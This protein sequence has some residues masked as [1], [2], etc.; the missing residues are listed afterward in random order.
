M[1]VN[2]QTQEER[3]PRP[4]WFNELWS[5]YQAGMCNVFILH[6]HTHDYVDDPENNLTVRQYLETLLVTR[7]ALA[8]FSPDEGV[9]FPGDELTS[10]ESAKWLDKVLG[11]DN[12]PAE[13]PGTFN[14]AALLSA[15]AQTSGS[16]FGGGSTSEP[17]PSDAPRALAMLVDY[18]K[19]ADDRAEGVPITEA[20]SGRFIA[21]RAAVL[22][23]RLD[24]IMPP[25]EKDRLG[26]GDRALLSLL[27]RAGTMSVINDRRNL[28][29]MLA[30]S[31]EE[32]HPDLRLAASGIR[33]IEVPP[34]DYDQRLAFCVRATA[35]RR[36]E[37]GN[38]TRPAV[39]LEDLQVTDLATQTAGLNRRHIEDLVLRAEVTKGPITREMVKARKREQISA[40]YAEVLEI[41]EP[42]VTF[43]MVGGHDAVKQY[44][45][46]WVIEPMRDSDPEGLDDIPMGILF[47]GPSGTGKTYLARALAKESGYNCVS[48]APDNIRGSYVG[49]SEKKLRK[50]IQGVEAMAPV[51]LFIDEIDQ[52]L[53]RTSGG[54]GGGDSVEGNIFGKM[55]EFLSDTRHRGSILL[56]A[57]TNEPGNIDPAL[58]RPGRIDNKIPLLPPDTAEERADALEALTRRHGLV[59]VD[60]DALLDVGR[61]TDSWTQAELEALV[62]K[63]RAYVRRKKLTPA[64]AFT[65]VLGRMRPSTAGIRRHIELAVRCCDDAS[66][67]PERWRSMVGT[68]PAPTPRPTPV[69]PNGR[70]GRVAAGADGFDLDDD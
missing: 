59:G 41:L 14:A 37:D 65:T 51:I 63:S 20:R 40:E 64:E 70:T 1:A 52:K 18:L 33:T 68:A 26:G 4:A 60:R 3:A 25:S 15:Q 55:L 43:D 42:D 45:R 17:L 54:G 38:V 23:E 58:Q 12:Q 9:L 5:D 2:P 16:G 66:L 57:A 22:V 56:V 19:Q 36:D 29:I 50:A 10:Q 69:V 30:P 53:R 48:M 31:L 49:E 11:R 35:E 47:A 27:H 28:M 32:I 62:V 13:A 44:L 6:G 7:Y 39:P 21:K 34:P 46:E 24:L 67:V 61:K 8:S